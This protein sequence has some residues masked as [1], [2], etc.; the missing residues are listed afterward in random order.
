MSKKRR[1]FRIVLLGSLGRIL[2]GSSARFLL[3]VDRCL[4]RFVEGKSGQI[5]G[6]T[7]EGP[8]LAGWLIWLTLFAMKV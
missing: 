3:S 2:V 1:V 4:I 8:S 5:Y 6:R 7:S